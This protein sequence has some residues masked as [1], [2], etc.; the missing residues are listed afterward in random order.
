MRENL[1][2]RDGWDGKSTRMAG[3]VTQHSRMMTFTAVPGVK[4]R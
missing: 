4:G 3:S 1:A 2:L